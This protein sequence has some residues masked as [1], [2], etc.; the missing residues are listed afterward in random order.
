[1]SAI[2]LAIAAGGA[3][4]CSKTTVLMTGEEVVGATKKVTTIA[5]RAVR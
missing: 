4:M 2:A 1:M 3:V 5:Q